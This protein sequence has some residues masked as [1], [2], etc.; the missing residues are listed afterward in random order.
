MTPVD[1][2]PSVPVEPEPVG[3]NDE[4]APT[5]ARLIEQGKLAAHRYHAQFKRHLH[6]IA[7][8][9]LWGAAVIGVVVFWHLVTPPVIH[10]LGDDQLRELRTVTFTIFG[11][12]VATLYFEK[13][14][15]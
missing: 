3:H 15:V 5:E 13:R 14:S 4:A 2:R 9:A 10:F 6:W 11:S 1:E 12:S 8:C 7:M